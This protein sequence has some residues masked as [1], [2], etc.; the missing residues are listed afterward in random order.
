MAM[1]TGKAKRSVKRKTPS[2]GAWHF[3][4][5]AC[6][7]ARPARTAGRARTDKLTLFIVHFFFSLSLSVLICSVVLRQVSLHRG[8]GI[9]RALVFA[10]KRFHG[11]NWYSTTPRY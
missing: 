6:E 10:A 1:V 4:R 2:L 11:I 7:S 9:L 5:H 3:T 8:P